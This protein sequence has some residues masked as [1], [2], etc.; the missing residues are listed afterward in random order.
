MRFQIHTQGLRLRPETLTRIEQHLRNTFIPFERFVNGVTVHLAA[1]GNSQ[2]EFTV[3]L[4]VHVN[5]SDDVV[6]SD[7]DERLG[8]LIN[9]AGRRAA[10]AVRRRRGR[11]RALRRRSRH[12]AQPLTPA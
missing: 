3:R 10:T 1:D 12:I 5:R 7:R 2:R 6:V 9:R 11:K 4:L 8:A